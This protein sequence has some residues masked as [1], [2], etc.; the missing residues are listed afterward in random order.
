MSDPRNEGETFR[1]ARRG[2]NIA[3]LVGLLAFVALIFIV[4]LVHVRGNALATGF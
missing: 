3:M 2:R 1:K 4:T